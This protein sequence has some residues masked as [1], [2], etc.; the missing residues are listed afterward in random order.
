MSRTIVATL[1]V[2]ALL[3]LL[4]LLSRAQ[5]TPPAPTPA[6]NPDGEVVTATD[7]PPKTP[8]ELK[9]AAWTMLTNSTRDTRKGDERSQALAAV[10]LL[11]N[12]PRG[13]KLITDAMTD[14][15]LD[16][17]SAA[18][19]AAGETKAVPIATPL[20]ALLDDKEPP[21][22]FSAAVALAKMK[23][24]SGEDILMSV[25]DGK[26]TTA[27][28]RMS[29]A[30]HDLDKN[31]HHPAGMAKFAAMQGAG[32]LLGPFGYGITA[33]EYLRKNG[34]DAARVT[35][36]ELLSENHTDP[37]RDELVAALIDNDPGVR[38]AAA[39]AL[40]EYHEPA[41]AAA[42][43][44]VFDDSKPPVRL[45]AA[46]AYLISTGEA[47]GVPDPNRIQPPRPRARKH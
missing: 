28:G 22:A 44:K 19:L 39:K 3:L 13:L 46:A 27:Q 31:L 34:G 10:G 23:D 15:D 43:G 26:R 16:I 12:S 45:T 33:Y 9:E 14:K 30:E 2:C 32:I 29:G 4:P 35:A 1:R 38:L 41:V 47:P 6:S 37:I 21:V 7:L 20:R 40:R 5:D 18:A 17:R 36:I 24:F 8:A 42:I 25:A 11:G